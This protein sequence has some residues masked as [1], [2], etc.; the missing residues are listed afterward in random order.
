MANYYK[1]PKRGN[2]L[3]RSPEMQALLT[4]KVQYEKA[5]D[6]AQKVL[7]N[8]RRALKAANQAQQN[9][10][11]DWQEYCKV[12]NEWQ[13]AQRIAQTVATAE[14][15]IAECK[16]RMLLGGVLALGSLLLAAIQVT[17]SSMLVVLILGCVPSCLYM[18][19]KIGQWVRA[20]RTLPRKSEVGDPTALGKTVEKWRQ[21]YERSQEVVRKLEDHSILVARVRSA[22]ADVTAWEFKITEAEIQL[23]RRISFEQQRK[24]QQQD[25]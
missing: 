17:P 12:W 7:E 4:Q 16:F 11:A 13:T 3:N 18:A 20:L 1:L 8:T 22:E 23:D 24:R 15:R 10:Q 25:L 9:A 5:W 21:R 19:A 6:E 14:T 2:D